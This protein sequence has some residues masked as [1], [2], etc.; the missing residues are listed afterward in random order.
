MRYSDAG[1]TKI[2]NAKKA[3]QIHKIF[4]AAYRVEA[5]LIGVE[6]FPP[7]DRTKTEV[8]ASMNDFYSIA[9]AGDLMGIMEIEEPF[10]SNKTSTIASLAVSPSY[11][12][13]GIGQ[14]LI[15]FA[16]EQ[17]SSLIVTTAEKNIPAIKLYEKMGF[18]LS[19]QFLAPGNISIVEFRYDPSGR[20]LTCS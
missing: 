7:L 12:R 4:Q 8:R 15:K 20:H 10:G 1:V 18:V 3:D 14:S 16:I 5:E 2:C 19:R 13:K 17:N 11:S 6:T 9:D